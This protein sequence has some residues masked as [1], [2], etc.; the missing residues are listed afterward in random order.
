MSNR[1]KLVL[2]LGAGASRPFRFPTAGE[3]REIIIGGDARPAVL[4]RL[5]G[6]HFV[7]A[8]E[9]GNRISHG[10]GSLCDDYGRQLSE[11][12]ESR[13]QIISPKALVRLQRAFDQ[14]DR[15]SID[16]FV[17]HLPAG[18]DELINAAGL[19]VAFTFLWLER[20]I[21]KVGGDWYQMLMEDLFRDN[22]EYDFSHL[23]IVTFNYERSLEWYFRHV[24]AHQLQSDELAR[25]HGKNLRV[26]HVYGSLGPLEGENPVS[27]G[28]IQS[29]G[30]AWQNIAL[31]GVRAK[32]DSWRDVN[33]ALRAAGRVA[34][35]GFGFWDENIANIDFDVLRGRAVHASCYRLAET[36]KGIVNA[37]ATITWGKP[38]ETDADFLRKVAI[39]R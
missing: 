14:S 32:N 33:D 31:A 12:F 7:S 16:T 25:E 21:G 15:I 28:A 24:F 34:F 30:S 1:A 3:L 2:I 9:R 4:K 26:I 27:Y 23:T 36:V 29:A 13:L 39:L 18:N 11:C 17:K 6:E 19:T 10:V 35:L 20:M 22:P 38:D 5:F 37:K 8:D